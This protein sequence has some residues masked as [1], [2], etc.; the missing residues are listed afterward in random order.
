MTLA[1]YGYY[2]VGAALYPLPTSTAFTPLHDADPALY[3]A[4]DFWAAMIGTYVGP[5]LLVEAA[6][7]GV[8]VGGSFSAAVVQQYP[9]DIGPVLLT[10]QL[11]FPLLACWR[12]STQYLKK[13]AVYYDDTGKF[14][15]AYVMPPLN[16]GQ[17]ERLFPFLRSIEATLRNRTDLGWDPNY[18]PPGGSAAQPGPFSSSF[19]Y[20]EEIGFTEGNYGFLPGTGN[21]SF[22]TLLMHGYIIERD[23]DVPDSFSGRQKFAGGDIELDLADGGAAGDGSTFPN[24]INVSTQQAPILTSLSVTTGSHLGGTS[25][26]ITGTL[27][28]TGNFNS[29][30]SEPP[31]VLFGNQLATSVVWNSSTSITCVTPAISGPGVVGVTVVN[32]DGQS[33]SLPLAFTFT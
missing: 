15:V 2:G 17:S 23:N 21:L 26:T 14:S 16:A 7:S 8:V 30:T 4:L 27:F 11:Q 25:V 1:D 10:N 9:Y 32:R 29:Q 24:L 5:R 19:A 12:T 33:G 18:I 28:L 31:S 20:I 22:P 13:S 3:Y 6:S